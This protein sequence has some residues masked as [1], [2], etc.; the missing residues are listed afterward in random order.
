MNKEI[1]VT[2]CVTAIFGLRKHRAHT[3]TCA[4]DSVISDTVTP[5]T[6]IT[7]NE[8]FSSVLIVLLPKKGS[9]SHP[10]RAG[11]SKCG[12]AFVNPMEIQ[13]HTSG[14]VTT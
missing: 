10:Y 6:V 2:A 8:L 13:M 7:E 4:T 1:Q 3:V 14:F 11:W 9:F 12:A 5:N